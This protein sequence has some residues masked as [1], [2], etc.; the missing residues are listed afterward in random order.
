MKGLA[1]KLGAKA[2][3][4]V[5]TVIIV[6]MISVSCS[7][8]DSDIDNL[9][10]EVTTLNSSVTSLA[11]QLSEAEKASAEAHEKL[12]SAIDELE[13][14]SASHATKEYVDAQ[15]SVVKAAAEAAAADAKTQAIREAKEYADSLLKE[16]QT[17]ADGKYASKEEVKS[18]MDE[19]DVKIAAI[20]PKLEALSSKDEDLQK[21]ISTALAQLN[22]LETK[23]KNFN[24]NIDSLMAVLDDYYTL[25]EAVSKAQSDIEAAKKDIAGNTKSIE[26]LN[27]KLADVSAQIKTIQDEIESIWEAVKDCAESLKSI[28]LIPEY[29]DNTVPGGKVIFYEID[30]GSTISKEAEVYWR[31]N[32]VGANLDGAS[33]AL[34]NRTVQTRAPEADGTD[35]IQD[36]AVERVDD[37]TLVTKFKVNTEFSGRSIEKN[38]YDMITLRVS[39]PTKVEGVTNTVYSDYYSV[40]NE[41]E[42]H[43]SVLKLSAIGE[44]GSV[45]LKWEDPS[46]DYSFAEISYV[47]EEGTTVTLKSNSG[48]NVDPEKGAGFTSYPVTGFYN[49]STYE[50][51]VTPYNSKGFKGITKSVKCAPVVP[52]LKVKL[53]NGGQ[54]AEI[55]RWESTSN[56][57]FTMD[58]TT[59]SCVITL[60]ATVDDSYGYKNKMSLTANEDMTGANFTAAPADGMTITS[61]AQGFSKD[62]NEITYTINIDWTKFKGNYFYTYVFQL[63]SLGKFVVDGS[64]KVF[65]NIFSSNKVVDHTLLEVV[66]SNSCDTRLPASKAVD[67]ITG[68]S[69]NDGFWASGFKVGRDLIADS[70]PYYID[71]KLSEE[72]SISGFKFYLPNKSTGYQADT[73]A[74]YIEVSSDMAT[75][76]KLCS[77]DL[78]DRSRYTEQQ[79][80]P[81]YVTCPPTTIKY[82]RFAVSETGRTREGIGPTAALAEIQPILSL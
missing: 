66:D 39:V 57:F 40:I 51:F 61:S 28:A 53:V 13:D 25:K 59:P 15:D 45:I 18:M 70:L 77:F 2:I 38:I 9:D 4:V 12:Q 8:Y 82:F 52:A 24:E 41:N 7:D 60:K 22:T 30:S 67:G 3:L 34:L 23:Y 47:N 14:L 5:M 44:E 55:F 19:L 29:Y 31:L 20:D 68:G 54:T 78:S 56:S 74:G 1:K 62:V 11:S 65:V 80:G 64:D 69:W 37:S 48:D 58:Y 46:D 10:D 32:P 81:F 76:T 72:K 17:N 75:W 50:F 26:D 36:L 73:K 63:K 6:P 35:L 33:Y 49:D 43:S 21:Q 71:I 79:T 42:N 16:F 27:T